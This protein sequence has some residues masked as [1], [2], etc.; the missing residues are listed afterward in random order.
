MKKPKLAPIGKARATLPL[1]KKQ[2]VGPKNPPAGGGTP[3]PERNKPG[4]IAGDVLH[5]YVERI[6]KLE[7]E[8]KAIA[9]DIK[10]IYLEVK[11]KGFDTKI[12]R[13]AI[14]RRAMDAAERQEQDELLAL[15][16]RTLETFFG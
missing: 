7:E 16:E 15:Y 10:D 8:K 13:K 5:G 2:P 12:V 11:A 9:A 4:G 14:K 3:A 1:P 6:E